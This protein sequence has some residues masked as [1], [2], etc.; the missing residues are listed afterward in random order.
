MAKVETCVCCGAIIPEGLGQYCVACAVKIYGEVAVEVSR[1]GA[2]IIRK[3]NN[4]D[5]KILDLYNNQSIGGN[6]NE[7]R[8]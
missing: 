6:A 3:E 4:V 5:P 7:V 1:D 2:R 8:K